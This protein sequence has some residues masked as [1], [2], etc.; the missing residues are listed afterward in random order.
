LWY[1]SG[2]NP[3][4]KCDYVT[5]NIV[6]SFNNWIK[7]IKDLPVCE[8][9]DKIRKKIMGLFHRRRRIGR[10]LECK[11]LPDVLRVLKA[12]TR[13]LGHLSYV[14][15]DNYIT[16]VRD[17]DDCHSKFV[18][19]ALHKECQCEEWQ[20][21]GLPCQY[22]LCLIIAQPFRDVKLEEF[23]DEYYSVEKFQNAYKRV[24]VP[25]GDKSFWPEV[26]IDEAVGAPLAKRPV[27]QQWKNRIK[28]CLEGGSGKKPSDKEKGKT[29]KLFRGQ[30]RCPNCGELGHRKNS[31]KC[32]LNGTKKRQDSSFMHVIVFFLCPLCNCSFSLNTGKGRQGSLA[33]GHGFPMMMVCRRKFLVMWKRR[34]L[35][36][37]KRCLCANLDAI[38]VESWVTGRIAQYVI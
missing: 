20:H 8:L 35:M 1:R 9:A 26:D 32:R 17:N 27:G 24:V 11:I 31:P 28:G 10:M 18:V 5:N 15:G 34:L 6:E 37:C 13:R 21:T 19:R 23:V 30:F 4:I 12:R 33:Q 7:D 38:I 36:V 2:F 22:A 16:E 14:K 25:L 29:R 3:A